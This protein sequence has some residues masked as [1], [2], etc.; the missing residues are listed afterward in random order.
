MT[1]L[2]VVFRLF[3]AFILGALI[4]I[5]GTVGTAYFYPQVTDTFIVKSPGVEQLRRDLDTV[6]AQR[7]EVTRR[8]EKLASVLEQVERRYEDLGRRFDAIEAGIRRP[9]EA[10]PPRSGHGGE[11]AD[12]P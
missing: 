10:P 5:L 11:P 12:V 4:G 1:K 2:V 7:D 8:L 9:R 6:V 3:I